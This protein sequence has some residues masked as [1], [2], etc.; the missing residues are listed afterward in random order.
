MSTV[1]SK[2]SDT[3]TLFQTRSYRVAVWTQNKFLSTIDAHP[4]V[5]GVLNI[6]QL[7]LA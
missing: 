3:L 1:A 2:F 4:G 5:P 7:R 6:F